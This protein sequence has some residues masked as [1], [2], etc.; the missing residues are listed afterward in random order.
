VSHPT[1]ANALKKCNRTS[2][3][4]IVRGTDA[5]IAA[6]KAAYRMRRRSFVLLPNKNVDVKL[7]PSQ[8]V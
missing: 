1:G 3:L 6:Q 5:T 8:L 2:G 4:G 7:A